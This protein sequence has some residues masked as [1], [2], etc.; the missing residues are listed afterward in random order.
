[1]D[2]FAK[3]RE[4]FKE[5]ELEWRIQSTGLKKDGKPYSRVLVYVT[6][7][8]IMDRLDS[9][10]GAENWQNEFKPWKDGA[11]CGLS[12]HLKIEQGT[13]YD[14]QWVTKWDGADDT[15]IESTKGGI[16][17][18]MKRCAVQWGV[19][20]YLYHV[21][22]SF[23]E[24]APDGRYSV[25]I[26][27]T[28][29]KWNPPAL[30]PAFLP[31]PDV[32]LPAYDPTEDAVNVLGGKDVTNDRLKV[33]TNYRFLKQVEKLKKE[34]NE[35]TGKDNVYYACLKGRATSSGTFA[36]HAN[37]LVDREEQRKFY[38]SLIDVRDSIKERE[39]K[40]AK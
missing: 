17:S 38:N 29:Y 9:V 3:L 37:N 27:N 6:N 23:A 15:D 39:E 25:K 2:I 34:L 10:L 11:L 8:A 20:R 30:A 7:R 36:E 4:P 18:A 24:F 28:W 16:S 40:E 21:G 22:D 32:A 35:L 26:D 5:D 13:V 1:M 14:Y 12:L 31:L 19:G 33:T